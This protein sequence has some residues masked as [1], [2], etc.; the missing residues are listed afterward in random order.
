MS[1]LPEHEWDGEALAVA[2]EHNRSMGNARDLVIM[3]WLIKGDTRPL[4]DWLLRGHVLGQEVITALAVMLIRGHPDADLRWL[5]DPA[6]KETADI[7]RLGLKVAGKPRGGGDPALHVRHKRIA[8]EVAY[9]IRSM[10]MNE[11]EAFEYVSEW[12][13]SN[14][15]RRM[16]PDNVKKAYNRYKC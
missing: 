16:G 8:L 9:A 14:G 13:R 15:Q 2:R 10:N 11:L 7:F 4:S 3:D 12:A 1:E 6:V 5:D